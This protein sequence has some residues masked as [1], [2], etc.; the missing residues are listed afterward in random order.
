MEATGA[1]ERAARRV[2]SEDTAQPKVAEPEDVTLSGAALHPCGSVM[3]QATHSATAEPR[4]TKGIVALLAVAAAVAVAN[5]YYAQPLA[6]VMK[7]DL[8]VSERAMGLALMATQAGYALGMLFLVPIGDGRERRSLLVATSGFAAVALVALAAAPSFPLVVAAS[9]LVGFAS[10]LPQMI[11]PYSV[12]LVPTEQRGRVIGTVMG[13]LLVG[14]LLSR[15]ASGAAGRLFG[16]R[17]TFAM[18]AALMFVLAVVLRI[19]LPTQEPETKRP[20]GALLRSLAGL[21]G[22]EPLLRR[23]AL[24]GALGFA[25]FSVFWSALA[26]HLAKSG[27]GS[28]VA[29]LFGAVGIV[30]VFVAPLVGR[31]SATVP[32]LRINAIGLAAIVASFVA[33]HFGARSFVGITL[34]VVLLD[35]GVQANHLSNQTVIFGLRPELRNRLNAIYMVVYFL[36]GSLGS[37]LS[38][39]AWSLGGWPAVCAVGAVLSGA[40]LAFAAVR[41]GG[42]KV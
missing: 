11:V 30:G 21:F 3:A 8:R 4:S 18:A 35:G 41:R 13:G 7:A 20:Y 26:F 29:G 6:A 12:G 39:I 33:F 23:H 22:S 14:I 36:G 27:Y 5:L 34:G 15:T 37:A 10:S 40:G 24:L 28:D 2:E 17:P 1:T 16:W 19:A 9:L 42:S 31:L 25:S 32:A 38:A